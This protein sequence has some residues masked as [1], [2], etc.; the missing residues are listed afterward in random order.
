MEWSDE[1]LILTVGAHGEAAAV[2]E[3]FTAQHGRHAALVHGGRSR[4][5]RPV[6]QIGNHVDATW[7]A[8]LAE[9]LG[10]ARIELR[11]AFAAEAMSDPLALAGLS[12][13]AALTRLLP[14]RDPHPSLFE[15]TLFVMSYLDDAAI[16]PALYARWELALLDALGFGLDLESCA[17]SGI[18]DD[19]IYVSPRSGRAVSASA[20]EP[21]RDK[22]LALPQFLRAGGRTSTTTNIDDVIAALALTGYFLDHR[23]MAPINRAMPDARTRLM[24]ML[25]RT[26]G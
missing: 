11:R 13:I 4:R 24:S 21:Y 22:L 6:L 12:S 20:G 2:V 23:V 19:L 8:R 5:Q 26:G 15:V 17:A 25:Q 7:K 3:L 10:H 1:G 9:Q 16:W 14:E 18:N